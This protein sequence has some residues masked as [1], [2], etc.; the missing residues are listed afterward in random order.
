MKHPVAISWR[1]KLSYGLRFVF[2]FLTMESVLHTMYVVAIKDAHAWEGD[3][4]ADL[5]MIGFW[6]LVVVWLKVCLPL[7]TMQKGGDRMGDRWD[8]ERAYGVSPDVGGASGE[9]TF[10]W[11]G[12]CKSTR[13]RSRS[14]WT[15]TGC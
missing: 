14:D 9:T 2:C 13:R 10:A 4:P 8:E 6:N 1:E 3:S 11:A 12:A 7:W 5:S 15:A